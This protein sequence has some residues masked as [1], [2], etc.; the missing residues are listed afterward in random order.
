[1]SLKDIKSYEEFVKTF[2]DKIEEA[3]PYSQMMLMQIAQESPYYKQY[4]ESNKA[5]S[6]IYEQ[7]LNSSQ[8]KGV[9]NDDKE[10]VGFLTKYLSMKEV[11]ITDTEA[12]VS[13]LMETN[14]EGNPLFMDYINEVN[15]KL[16]NGKKI[17]T[18]NIG[19]VVNLYTEAV[20]AFKKNEEVK[21]E[22]DTTPETKEV[23]TMS[24]TET[25]ASTSTTETEG[26]T[27]RSIFDH[28]TSYPV[29]AREEME[30][31]VDNSTKNNAEEDN[32]DTDTATDI[33]EVINGE[34]KGAESLT[35]DFIENS[36]QEVTDAAA[37][38]MDIANREVEKNPNIYDNEKSGGTTNVLE[39]I[40]NII[41]N[42]DTRQ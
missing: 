24:P 28:A 8:F 32:E 5:V 33:D 20:K 6:N 23:S 9:S 37:K 26:T 1:M 31:G 41:N 25:V 17:S 19:E 4:L 11:D 39:N 12:V 7:L 21:K 3:D 36:S 27:T 29:G 18:D 42:K 22:I 30:D 38:A 2:E 35:D 40:K 16:P 13:K 14:A 10:L 15:K 34:A